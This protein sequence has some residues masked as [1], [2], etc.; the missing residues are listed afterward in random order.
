[1]QQRKAC[2][3]SYS[4]R[5]PYASFKTVFNVQSDFVLVSPNFNFFAKMLFSRWFLTTSFCGVKILFSKPFI[6]EWFQII[7]R[8]TEYLCIILLFRL[9]WEVLKWADLKLVYISHQLYFLLL[10]FTFA[11]GYLKRW[12]CWLLASLLWPCV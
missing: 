7:F 8:D 2:W 10:A 12:V 5:P 9:F 4:A 6:S 11:G 1:M 3:K